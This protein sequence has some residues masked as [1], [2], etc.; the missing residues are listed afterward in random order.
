MFNLQNQMSI[1]NPP[2]P[3]IL[4]IDLS[5]HV[6]RGLLCCHLLLVNNINI[7]CITPETV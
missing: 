5:L 2:K 7:N 3:N 4:L 1:L 6:K